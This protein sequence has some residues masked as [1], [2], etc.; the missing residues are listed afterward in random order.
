MHYTIGICRNFF[1]IC[2]MHD[3]IIISSG[4]L[5]GG[6]GIANEL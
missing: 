4:D 5:D 1:K 2:K 3:N 6:K